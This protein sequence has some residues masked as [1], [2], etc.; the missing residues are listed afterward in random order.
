MRSIADNAQL[1]LLLEVSSTPKPGNV[2]REHEYEDLRFEHFVAGGAGA[3]TG[4]D[5]AA[6]GGPVGEAFEHAI[7]GMSTQSGGNTQFGAILL[8]T[9]LAVAVARGQDNPA[10]PTDPPRELTPEMASEVVAETTVEDA[11]GFYRGFDHVSVAVDEPPDDLD[12]PDV[13]LGADAAPA[14]REQELT[15]EA[16]MADSA[17]IDGLAAE[18]VGGFERTF[19]TARRIADRDGPVTD[20]AAGVFLELLAEEIDTFVVTQHDHETAREVKQR[21]TAA[22]EG[23]ES[24]EDLAAE[25]VEREINPGTTAD[26]IAGGLFIALERGLEV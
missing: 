26:L 10:A 23:D 2:D 12:A 18:W 6:E 7:D 1:A 4:L 17:E 9:P 13:R 16:V 25:F 8:V 11:I 15:L 19:E 5:R 14:L 21:A 24:A 20:R 3:R 22:L